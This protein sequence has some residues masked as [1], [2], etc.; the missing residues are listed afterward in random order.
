MRQKNA[1]VITGH[2]P[3]IICSLTT[4]SLYRVSTVQTPLSYFAESIKVTDDIL[5]KL[6]KTDEKIVIGKY[7][8]VE[9]FFFFKKRCFFEPTLMQLP[10]PILYQWYSAFPQMTT[11][12]IAYSAQLD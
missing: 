9:Y 1:P 2:R 3:A 8:G 6:Y 5:R 12:S 11:T 10:S 4:L 7:S